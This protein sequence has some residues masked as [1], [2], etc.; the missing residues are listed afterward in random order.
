VTSRHCLLHRILDVIDALERCFESVRD[1]C[2][3]TSEGLVHVRVKD[4]VKSEHAVGLYLVGKR[5]AERAHLAE[6]R[7]VTVD[8]LS[9]EL[10]IPTGTVGYAL[11]CLRDKRVIE[12]VREGGGVAHFI[13]DRRIESFVGE[14]KAKLNED[15]G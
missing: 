6:S 12:R 15:R 7:Q 5:Y 14:V 13:P 2:A 8:E 9:A 3:I 11:K 1:F 10:G 4:E